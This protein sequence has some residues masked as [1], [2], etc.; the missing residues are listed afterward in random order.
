MK[1]KPDLNR[2]STLDQMIV[3]FELL[4][5]PNSSE[6]IGW[7]AEADW[8]QTIELLKK[9]RELETDRDWTAFHTNEFIPQ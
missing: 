2:Q 6:R 5:S 8:A 1:V 9:Y 3:D 4:R 7:G